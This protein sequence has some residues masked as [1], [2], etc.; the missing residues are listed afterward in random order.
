M[1]VSIT[2]KSLPALKDRKRIDYRDAAFPSLQGDP[3]D[4]VLM[5][6]DGEAVA[7]G[8][9]DSDEELELRIYRPLDFFGD[10][11]TVKGRFHTASVKAQTDCTVSPGIKRALLAPGDSATEFSP[12]M[13]S[14]A[15]SGLFRFQDVSHPCK[16]SFCSLPMLQVLSIESGIFYSVLRK[17]EMEF[18]RRSG[19]SSTVDNSIVSLHSQAKEG[20]E[21]GDGGTW[22][23]SGTTEE[24]EEGNKA[25]V[26]KE[27][28]SNQE[29]STTLAIPEQEKTLVDQELIE[30]LLQE[31]TER[32]C[33]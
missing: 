21:S 19:R 7:V 6:K 17:L 27:T 2:A 22:N 3:A 10:I 28:E 30:R 31:D 12:E 29:T 23:C 33:Y 14:V 13:N 32:V 11:T 18:R 16:A 20:E 5:V 9:A 1:Q 4:R 15:L 8:F 26:P 25:A 24:V